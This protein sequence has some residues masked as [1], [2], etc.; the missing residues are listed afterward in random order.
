MTEPTVLGSTTG[1][2]TNHDS[3]YTS[4][5]SAAGPNHGASSTSRTKQKHSSQVETSGDS[6]QDEQAKNY[7]TMDIEPPSGRMW[8]CCANEHGQNPYVR[9]GKATCKVEGCEHVKCGGCANYEDL[10]DDLDF[11]GDMACW[12][13]IGRQILGW[14]LFKDISMHG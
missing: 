10:I 6:D 9:N 14:M 13:T 4:N 8:R 12:A 11:L 2:V 1:L 5:R 7:K 3:D